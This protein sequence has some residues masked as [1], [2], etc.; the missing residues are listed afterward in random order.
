MAPPTYLPS[1]HGWWS[2]HGRSNSGALVLGRPLGVGEL[3]GGV[4]AECPRRE[5]RRD[6]N[7]LFSHV[8][9][10]DRVLVSLLPLFPLPCGLFQGRFGRRNKGSRGG[11]SSWGLVKTQQPKCCVGGGGQFDNEGKGE[12]DVGHKVGDHV[13]CPQWEAFVKA[14]H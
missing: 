14:T 9:Q 2:S 6:S 10:Q 4:V 11:G 5:M 12:S 13:V 8:R 3:A 7:A 1:I